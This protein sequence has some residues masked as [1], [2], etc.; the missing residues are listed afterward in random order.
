MKIYRNLIVDGPAW[1]QIE[2]H[3]PDGGGRRLED[4]IFVPVL[5][6]VVRVLDAS[7]KTIENVKTGYWLGRIEVGRLTLETVLTLRGDGIFLAI[8]FHDAF[9][10]ETRYQLEYFDGVFFL[11]RRDGAGTSRLLDDIL[12]KSTSR[13]LPEKDG[14]NGL[15]NDT[16]Q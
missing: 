15:R 14:G 4:K 9:D 8:D 6:Y 3:Y 2:R 16:P 7:G 11:L 10:P 12:S 1:E 5:F 13:S